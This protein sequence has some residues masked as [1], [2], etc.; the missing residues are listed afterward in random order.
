MGVFTVFFP[1]GNEHLVPVLPQTLLLF[2]NLKSRQMLTIGMVDDHVLLRNCLAE[3]LERLGGFKVIFQ[4]NNG[5]HLTKI[6]DPS[7]PPDV[8]ITD[9]NMPGMNGFET[10]AWITE[11]YPR[12][13]VVAL[14][15]QNDERTIIRMLRS[16]A[17]AYLLKE[18]E[19]EDLFQ[20][21]RDVHYKGIHINT[22]L[23]NNIVQS[24]KDDPPVTEEEEK[25]MLAALNERE[26]EFLK[27][28][29]TDKS[30]KEIAADM[31]LSP[32]TID[33]YRD[34]LFEKLRVSSRIGLVL[35]AIRTR[36]VE[37]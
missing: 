29:C 4:A 23:Y 7:Q 20:A 21:V 10:A 25:L 26:I 33:G 36:I 19:L 16:G 17:K 2:I 5:V 3:V 12:T 6:F 32:R 31:F 27:L 9:V 30:Y 28:V 13:K 24:L 35:F 15:M 22:L 1:A 14:S 37:I 11:H 8:V 34:L 18:T